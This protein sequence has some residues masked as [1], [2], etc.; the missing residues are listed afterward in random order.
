MTK[1]KLIYRASSPDEVAILN[2]ARKYKY[3]FHGRKENGHR[4]PSECLPRF[5]RRKALR[6][7]FPAEKGRIQGHFPVILHP[8]ECLQYRPGQRLLPD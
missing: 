3:I 1:K 2:F 6:Y 7:H 4:N 5:C 8:A